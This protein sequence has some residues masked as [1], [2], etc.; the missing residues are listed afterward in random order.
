MAELN[1]KLHIKYN[2]KQWDCKLYTTKAEVGGAYS[3]ILVD[4]VGCFISLGDK[5]R[6]DATRAMVRSSSRYEFAILT[7]GTPPYGKSEY[8]NAGTYTWTAPAGVTKVRVTVAGGGGGGAYSVYFY[9]PKLHVNHNGGKGASV[10]QTVSVTP[11]NTYTISVGSGGACVKDNGNSTKDI[12]LQA[13]NGNASSAFNISARGGGG[14]YLFIPKI[15]GFS[16]RGHD[17][18]SY[19]SG[20]EGGKAWYNNTKS[21]GADNGGTGW[22]I[23]EYGQG[24]Q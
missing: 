18:T 24:V 21:Y 23:I 4:G 3:Y 9:N 20:G 22:V 13:G 11:K 5:N 1:K 2:G 16:D 7:S 19:G 6:S 12:E 15:S 17:G 10:T 14:A 8:R